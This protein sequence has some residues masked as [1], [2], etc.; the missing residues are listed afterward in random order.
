LVEAYEGLHKKGY[1]HRDIKPDNVM[2]DLAQKK[3][4]AID[5]GFVA[6]IDEKSK[7]AGCYM[8]T[9]PEAHA[10]EFPNLKNDIYAIGIVAGQILAL[11]IDNLCL[12][13]REDQ[14]NH[15]KNLSLDTLEL[16]REKYN[17]LKD[18]CKRMRPE[19]LEITTFI[20]L[21]FEFFPIIFAADSAYQQRKSLS[22]QTIALCNLLCKMTDPLEARP[23]I[24]AVLEKMREIR[25]EHI[26]YRMLSFK[27]ASDS[28][29]NRVLNELYGSRSQLN[30]ALHALDNLY[31][32]LLRAVDVNVK[33][34]PSI[35][36][37]IQYLNKLDGTLKQKN[38]LSREI[39]EYYLKK[40]G[41]TLELET[42]E[43]VEAPEDTDNQEYFLE[44]E[45]VNPELQNNTFNSLTNANKPNVKFLEPRSKQGQK[46]IHIISQNPEI[47]H[48]QENKIL[49]QKVRRV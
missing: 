8:Y 20:S 24:N 46:R 16:T 19:A 43:Q 34:R 23:D 38:K 4:I 49:K 10:S 14:F 27:P 25:W 5:F 11:S 36:E 7:W 39:Q 18:T 29:Y 6:K 48:E 26:K 37:V 44:K 17:Y 35:E 28:E 40:Q 1:A 3:C 2:F 30:N 12:N 31:V 33:N 32:F 42:K 13:V 45:N 22:V 15:Y 9:P 47:Q 41:N 21:Y